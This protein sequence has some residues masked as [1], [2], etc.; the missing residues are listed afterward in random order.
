MDDSAKWGIMTAV[1]SI[2]L[3]VILA[4]QSSIFGDEELSNSNQNAIPSSTDNPDPLAFECLDHSGL[5]R[6]DHAT[7]RIFVDGEE[8]SIPD[9]IGINTG[10]CNQEGENMHIV[11]IHQG[12]PNY[13]HIES[14][15]PID[16]PLGVFFDIWDVHFDD[17]GIFDL[18]VNDTHQMRMTVDGVES[19]E[20]DNLLLLDGQTIAIYYEQI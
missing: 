2:V 4:T 7:L 19:N 20:F 3:V 6:H 13:L 1:A 14:T 12:N 10:V 11:H 16:I 8:R 17:S 5:A 18:R 15:E 9:T